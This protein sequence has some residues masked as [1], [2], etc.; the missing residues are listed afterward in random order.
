MWCHL[1]FHMILLAVL[2]SMISVET[3]V[4]DTL[5]DMIEVGQT[6]VGKTSEQLA[7]SSIQ[8]SSM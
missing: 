4:T 6:I 7:R 2:M 3:H 8:C 5:F 1:Y